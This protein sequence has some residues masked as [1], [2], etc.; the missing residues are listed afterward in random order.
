[1]AKQL[2]AP[3]GNG[4][5]NYLASLELNAE[6]IEARIRDL[7]QQLAEQEALRAGVTALIEAERAHPTRVRRKPVLLRPSPPKAPA[8]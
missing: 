7:R 6:L 3:I 2:P 5:T 1:M 8:A 4:P